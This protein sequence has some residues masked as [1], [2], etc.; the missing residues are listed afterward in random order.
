M[1]VSPFL[2]SDQ[3]ETLEFD[4]KKVTWLQAIPISEAEYAY[5]DKNGAEA[6]EDILEEAEVDILDL[7]RKSTI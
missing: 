4:D 2:W 7:E 6:L 3:L 5:V 1:F